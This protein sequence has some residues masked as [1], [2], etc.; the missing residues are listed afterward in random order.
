MRSA[1]SSAPGSVAGVAVLGAQ[2]L[3][4]ESEDSIPPVIGPVIATYAQGVL[5]KLKLSASDLQIRRC[6]PG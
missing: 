4:S 1:C 2:S 5:S 3:L 6:H